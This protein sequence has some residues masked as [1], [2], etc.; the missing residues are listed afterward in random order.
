[1]NLSNGHCNFTTGDLKWLMYPT[2]NCWSWI[3][4]WLLCRRME[5]LQLWWHGT[6]NSAAAGRT[7]DLAAAASGTPGTKGPTRGL[8]APATGCSAAQMC[9]H[10]RTPIN[11]IWR[12]VCLPDKR[13]TN[14]KLFHVYVTAENVANTL[15]IC[16]RT[17]TPW[18]KSPFGSR[19]EKKW[20]PINFPHGRK[21]MST[22]WFNDV[23]HRR[24]IST[25]GE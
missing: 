19:N 11:W 13:T 21:I 5:H 8:A 23:V 2:S 7:S 18:N 25:D 9:L 4:I 14:V 15:T 16:K 1:M 6:A 17:G 20:I 22:K 3:L 12:V 10:S 24:G